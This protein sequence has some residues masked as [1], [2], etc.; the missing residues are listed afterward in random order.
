MRLLA[1]AAAATTFQKRCP[2][3]PFYDLIVLINYNNYYPAKKSRGRER[4]G[5]S[6]RHLKESLSLSF[7]GSLIILSQIFRLTLN[8][9]SI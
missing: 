5:F 4:A 7:W 3:M 6:S 9:V 1:A 2:Q 8:I